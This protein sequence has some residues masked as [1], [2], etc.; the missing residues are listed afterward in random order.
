MAGPTLHA[1][2]TPVPMS[3][4]GKGKTAAGRPWASVRDERPTGSPQPAAV[5]MAL[6]PNRKGEPLQRHLEPFAGL[7]RA[8]G[9]TGSDKVFN[10]HRTHAACRAHARRTFYG[11]TRSNPSPAAGEALD[12]IAALD[13][14]EAQISGKPP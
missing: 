11:L 3:A 10:D 7:P 2:D 14:I 9:F 4:P 13:A 1:D 5:W 6:T 12:R 8:G